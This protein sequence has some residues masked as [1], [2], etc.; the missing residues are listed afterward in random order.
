MKNLKQIY[1]RA[2]IEKQIVEQSEKFGLTI[3]PRAK[4][5]QLSVGQQQRL[6]IVKLLLQGAKILILDEPTAVLTPQEAEA[7]YTTLRRM[8]KNGRAIMSH[9]A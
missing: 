7:L 4:V 1:N 5:W 9:L 2:E 6:E 3:D 8:A